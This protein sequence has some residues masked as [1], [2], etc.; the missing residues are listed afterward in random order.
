MGPIALFDKSFLQ[1]L[2]VDE[3]VWFDH[4]FI[5]NICPLFYV[6]TLADLE[7]S[8]R[9]GRTPEIEVGLIADKT[10]NMSGMPC[11]Q[12]STLCLADLMGNRVAMT[13]Q[14]PVPGGRIVDVEGKRGVVYDHSPEHKAFSRWQDRS[15]LEVER[16]FA[17]GWRAAIE[18]LD[19]LKVAENF[20]ALGV[21]GKTCSTL[22]DAR[23][24]AH[25]IVIAKD[26]PFERMKLAITT[27][28]VPHHLYR[29]IMERW[30][31][32]GRPSIDQFAPYAAHVLEVELFFQISLAASLIGPQR[33]SN[34]VDIA[35]LNYLPFCMVFASSDRL[36]QRCAPLFMRQDQEFVWGQD[37]KTDLARVNL[38]YENFPEDIKEKGLFAFAHYPPGSDG[39]LLVQLWDRH[40]PRWRE[41][42]R[43]DKVFVP[44]KMPDLV[45]KLRKFSDAPGKPASE[46]PYDPAEIENVSIQRVVKKRKGSWFQ[47]AKDFEDDCHQ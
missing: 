47:I 15:F 5:P 4:F 18:Q 33:A 14:I 21:N 36:H 17:K 31:S 44:T 40:A 2:S 39:D 27:L 34:R 12:H 37:L 42:D 38:H 45:A 22:H 43:N 46:L 29:P 26:K 19:L 24:L 35:Y 28:N 32:M 3:S 11:S 41:Q 30:A 9:A 6:E 20:R 1:S 10:P 13:M 25:Q 16:Q 8:V 7:K 23:E